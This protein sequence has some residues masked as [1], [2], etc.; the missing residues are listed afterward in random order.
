MTDLSY[1]IVVMENNGG[2]EMLKMKGEKAADE[3]Q[4]K[5]RERAQPAGKLRTINSRIRR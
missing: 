1:I 4:V 5:Y 2:G 3:K